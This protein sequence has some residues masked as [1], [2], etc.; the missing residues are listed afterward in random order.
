MPT[1]AVPIR[2]FEA[3]EMTHDDF[4]VEPVRGLPAHPPEGERILWQGAPDWQ[5]LARR[6]LGLRWVM[7]YFVVLAVWRGGAIGEVEGLREGLVAGT[8]YLAMGA[9]AGGI[10]ALMAYGMARSTVYTITNRRV[11]MRIGMALTVTL[12]LPYR[13]IGAASVHI[14]PGGRGDIALSLN[15]DSRISYLVCWPHVRPWTMS[16]TQPALRCV[17]DARR[18]ATILGQAAETRVAEPRA[19]GAR[20]TGTPTTGTPM[21]EM[22]RLDHGPERFAAE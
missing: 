17:P 20:L 12:N 10:L 8:W 14:L 9:V 7:G 2:R 1:G 4:A 18:V 11:A 19:T 3:N 13:A 15:E 6:A 21:T 16:G 22:G 5:M